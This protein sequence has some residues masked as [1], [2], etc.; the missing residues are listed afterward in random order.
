MSS[1]LPPQLD[2]SGLF[3]TTGYDWGTPLDYFDLAMAL[4][5]GFSEATY[6]KQIAKALVYWQAVV[7]A[8]KADSLTLLK[9]SW[10]VTWLTAEGVRVSNPPPNALH[11]IYPV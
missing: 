1:S 11:I 7:T 6:L 5:P 3:L 4:I 9:A 2:A 8:A 10:A